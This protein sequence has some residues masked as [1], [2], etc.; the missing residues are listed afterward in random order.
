ML[1][2]L[3]G[4]L[5]A[6]FALSA[7]AQPRIGRYV[8]QDLMVPMRDGVRL[9]TQVWR[10][11]D[12]TG[13]LPLLMLRSP[14]GFTQAR[15]QTFFAGAYAEL[16]ASGYVFVFQDIRGREGSEGCFVAWRPQAG[17]RGGVDES[18]DAWDSIDW[19][20]RHLS[21]HNGRVGMFGISYGGWTTAMAL[22]NPH[23]A[24]KAVSV[25]ASPDDLFVGDDFHHHGA[26]RLDYAWAY[27]AALET[28]GR[29]V[30]PFDFR[31]EDAYDWYLR[32]PALPALDQAQLGRR[33]PSWQQFMRHPDRDAYWREAVTSDRL[34]RE[35]AVPNLIVA[36][37]W[38]AEDLRGPLEIYRRQEAHD[39]R[40]RNFLVV[41]PW[42]HGGWAY[43][44]GRRFGLHD[45]G[46]AT[47]R[48]FRA[49]VQAPWFGH[50]L[51]DEPW[52]GLPEALV[53]QTGSNRWQRH[54][55][56]PPR[57]G[58]ERRSL[59]LH[60]GG[61]LSF[62]PPGAADALPDRFVSDPA[63][64][65]PYRERPIASV[66]TAGSTWS[67]WLADD[68]APF[69]RRSDVRVWVSEPLAEDLAVAGPIDARLFAATTGSDADWVVKLVDVHPDDA[70]QP[71]ALRGRHKLVASDVLRARYRHGYA[72]PLPLTPNEVQA[73]D[74]PLLAASHVFRKGHRVAVHVQGSWFPLI[75][76]NPQTFVPSI[77]RATPAD[78]RAQTH[79][80][81]H[82]AR[83]PSAVS[84]PVVTSTP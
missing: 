33:L 13:P 58:V 30:L 54:A 50:W 3:C 77:Y 1:R 26:F 59:Y 27:V 7:P 46:A 62:E 65:V 37:W 23:P 4:L 66:M 75:D 76:R 35:P 29:R 5:L 18:T 17:R 14:Y 15:L 51:K 53:F 70:A 6:T 74:I 34:P 43:G 8:G 72:Q 73:Y 64:P 9:H 38:D 78:F 40:G 31:G 11:A 79:T 80:L 25:Q 22:V 28:D 45:L 24:L 52:P 10:P 39:R 63:H 83:R 55:A 16:A 2:L 60:A 69:A 19:L 44:D 12:A 49:E 82:D 48:Q 71:A 47:A 67:E 36:G 21:G 81:F 84:L 42:T 68:Q 41:G 20:L 57:E 32:Q 61:R 56:W